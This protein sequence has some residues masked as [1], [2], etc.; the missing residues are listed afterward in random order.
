MAHIS[1]GQFLASAVPSDEDSGISGVGRVRWSTPY[2][3]PRPAL[4]SYGPYS[5]G[6]CRYGLCGHARSVASR[7][8]SIPT[9]DIFIRTHARLE[10]SHGISVANRAI[11]GAWP[12][13]AIFIHTSY[14]IFADI[15]TGPIVYYIYTI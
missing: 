12:Y 14:N 15:P 3:L 11:L 8:I 6:L 4:N 5:L 1:V 7:A 9:H 13:L 10:P 2:R